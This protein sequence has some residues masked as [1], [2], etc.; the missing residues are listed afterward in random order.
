MMDY[1]KNILE[2]CKRKFDKFIERIL[3]FIIFFTDWLG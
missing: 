2:R 3:D 1:E